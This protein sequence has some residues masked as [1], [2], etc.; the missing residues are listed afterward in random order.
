MQWCVTTGIVYGTPISIAITD[1]NLFEMPSKYQTRE[2]V[3]TK[4]YNR[5][6]TS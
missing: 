6:T 4:D 3:F 5:I 1:F 2:K